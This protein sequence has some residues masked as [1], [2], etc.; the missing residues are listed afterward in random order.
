MG[1]GILLDPWLR[2][3]LWYWVEGLL[4]EDRLRRDSYLNPVPICAA[5]RTH[6]AGQASHGCRLR[7]VLMFQAWLKVNS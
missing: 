3:T 5:W 6:L 2:G 7:P 4:A 1:F